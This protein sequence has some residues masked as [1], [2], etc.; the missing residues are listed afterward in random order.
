M[1]EEEVLI[2]LVMRTE[3][4]M[5]EINEGEEHVIFPNQE[6]KRSP[7]FNVILAIKLGTVRGNTN[8]IFNAIIVTSLDTILGNAETKL[9]SRKRKILMKIPMRL[10][11]LQFC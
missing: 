3:S 6:S 4:I 9:T 10:W 11:S 1:E 5:L 8:P 7:K 2:P